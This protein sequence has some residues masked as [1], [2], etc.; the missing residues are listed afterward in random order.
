MEKMSDFDQKLSD[1]LFDKFRF[2]SRKQLIE[3]PK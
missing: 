1:A 2:F 3:K